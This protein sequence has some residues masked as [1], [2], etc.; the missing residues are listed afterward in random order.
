MECGLRPAINEARV[1]EHNAVVW[2]L[3]K[4]SPPQKVRECNCVERSDLEGQKSLIRSFYWTIFETTIR[5]TI[6]PDFRGILIGE[7]RPSPMFFPVQSIME[8]AWE[9]KVP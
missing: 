5:Q 2:K 7:L 8:T 6:S 3:L 4:R 1:G 9:T